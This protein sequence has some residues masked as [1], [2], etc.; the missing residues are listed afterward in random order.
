MRQERPSNA[1][2][3][4]LPMTCKSVMCRLSRENKRYLILREAI[5]RGSVVALLAL[6]GTF[7]TA[8]QAS[9]VDLSLV[10]T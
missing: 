5:V 1:Q 3:R 10:S 7:A 4:L 6:L 9:F 8:S 2:L